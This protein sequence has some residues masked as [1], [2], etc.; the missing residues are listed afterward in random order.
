MGETA[1]E[2]EPLS[3]SSSQAELDD[4]RS[5]RE[6]RAWYRDSLGPDNAT[7]EGAA[8][9]HAPSSTPISPRAFDLIV[10]FEVSSRALYDARFQGAIW[11]GNESGVTV[12]IGYDVGYASEDELLGDWGGVIAR[13]MLNALF[14]VR[15]V[16][17][18]AAKAAAAGLAGQVNITFD[19]AIAVHRGKV[20]P[21][22]IG[23][24]EGK[25]ANTALLSGDSLGALVSLTY[26]RG[27]SFDAPG[28]RF[29]EMR[30]IK[31]HMAARAFALVASDMRDMKHLWPDTPG[32][33]TRRERE[34]Q[35]FERGIAT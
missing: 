17:G 3:Q 31:A 35:L 20:I 15:G 27:A 33:Q 16:T 14:G 26:N 12:G 28:E 11:P 23:L 1:S 9:H 32:L 30:S 18:T 8:I 34:A 19:A 4:A 10:E 29:T 24:V 2:N 13:P 21:R 6:G 5:D 25:L 7:A 22:W